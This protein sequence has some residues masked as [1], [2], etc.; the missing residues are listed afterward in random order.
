MGLFRNPLLKI[1]FDIDRGVPVVDYGVRRGVRIG[2]Q[3]NPLFVALYACKELKLE[4][5]TGP[6]LVPYLEETQSGQYVKSAVDWLISNQ[7]SRGSILVWECNFPWPSYNLLPPWRSALAE[8]FGALLLL[9]SG[10]TKDAIAHLSAMTTDYRNGGVAFIDNGSIWFLEY[11]SEQ[12]PVI[13]NCMM[14]CLLIL[15]ECSIRLDDVALERAFQVGYATLKRNL[16]RFD[17][18]FYTYYDS[19]AKPA[20]QK[21]HELHVEL[22]RLLCEKTGDR[23]LLPH[24][25]QWEK[26]NR[27]YPLFEPMIFLRGMATSKRPFFV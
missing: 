1:E 20:D 11:V 24:L 5:I 9:V 27:M 2:K 21:Y 18:G 17:A 23:A 25:R 8:A 6:I 16:G 4:H 15:R 22:L 3:V 7:R 13:L 19:E 10:R 12:R 26:Y 14:H